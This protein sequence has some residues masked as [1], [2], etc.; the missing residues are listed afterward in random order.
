M[1]YETAPH[2]LKTSNLS[3]KITGRL[4]EECNDKQ[5]RIEAMSARINEILDGREWDERM[6]DTGTLSFTPI[7]A[8]RKCLCQLACDPGARA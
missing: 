3:G 2:S 6:L 8:L 1:F 5:R 4:T 7:D